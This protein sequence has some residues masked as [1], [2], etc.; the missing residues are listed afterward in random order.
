MLPISPIIIS[1]RFY[2]LSFSYTI[3]RVLFIRKNSEN[4][5][6]FQVRLNTDKWCNCEILQFFAFAENA[7]MAFVYELIKFLSPY[8]RRLW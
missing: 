2:V 3:C 1:A 7:S 6:V 5:Y 4:S 8:L